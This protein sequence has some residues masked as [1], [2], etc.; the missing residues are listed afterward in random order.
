MNLIKFFMLIGMV[1][2]SGCK[3]TTVIDEYRENISTTIM[4]EG[5]SIVVLG[6]RN[7]S[8]YE[9]EFDFVECVGNSLDNALSGINVIPE[10]SFVDS[11]YPYFETSKAPMDVQNLDQL[12]Q[13]PEVANKLNDFKARYFVWID[14]FTETTDSTGAISCTVAPTGA[15]CFGFATWDDEANYE[16]VIWDFK[17]LNLSGKISAES[18]GTSYLPAVI[19][20]IPLL[21][22]VQSSACSSMASQIRGFIQ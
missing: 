18:S 6:R 2:I 20:P 4:S 5:E 14:G 13:I 9:T 12:V 3:S 7:N 8:S 10:Q 15:G 11:M 1:A 17:D 16:A 22:R 19:V 21:A